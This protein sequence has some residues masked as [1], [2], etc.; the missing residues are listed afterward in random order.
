MIESMVK[1]NCRDR[2]VLYILG[3]DARYTDNDISMP[4]KNGEDSIN[5]AVDVPEYVFCQLH[6]DMRVRVLIKKAKTPRTK[7]KGAPNRYEL[8]LM[9]PVQI[10]RP[11]EPVYETLRIPD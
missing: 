5:T 3:L 8:E 9:Y 2:G 7:L 11:A 4:N 6:P 10:E 1:I